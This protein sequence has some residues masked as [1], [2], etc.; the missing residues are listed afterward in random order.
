MVWNI[1][2]DYLVGFK[3][4]YDL[5]INLSIYLFFSVV[6]TLHLQTRAGEIWSRM[7]HQ[8]IAHQPYNDLHQVYNIFER[9]VS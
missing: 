9:C 5:S 4:I 3:S 7:T 8:E 6:P 1:Q 2:F